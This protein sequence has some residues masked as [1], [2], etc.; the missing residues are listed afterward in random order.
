VSAEG[1]AAVARSF[2]MPLKAAG[3][4]AKVV[5]KFAPAP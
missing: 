1:A 2:A 4:D 5:V 3:I